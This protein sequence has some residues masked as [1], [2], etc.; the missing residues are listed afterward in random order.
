MKKENS[1][2]LLWVSIAAAFA[3]ILELFGLFWHVNRVPEDT[4][5][6]IL[7]IIAIVALI[8]VSMG[9]YLQYRQKIKKKQE[10]DR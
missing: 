7:Y 9:F 1:K 2:I 8:F 6:T 4:I 5:G 3:V 10:E